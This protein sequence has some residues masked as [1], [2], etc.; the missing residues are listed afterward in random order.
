MKAVN[1]EV[2]FV[3]AQTAEQALL[4]VLCSFNRPFT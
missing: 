4:H 3:G 1:I 2:I